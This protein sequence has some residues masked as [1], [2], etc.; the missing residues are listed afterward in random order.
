VVRALIAALAAVVPCALARAEAPSPG[1]DQRVA[2]I[3]GLLDAIESI[4][5]TELTNTSN[6]IYAVERNKCQAPVESLHVGCLL[7]ATARNC[8]SRQGAARERCNRASDVLVTNR[9]SETAFLPEDVRYEIMDKHRDYG[10]ALARELERRYAIVVAELVMSRHFPGSAADRTR[11]AAGI[12]SYCRELSS[13]RALPWQ[14]CV[15][16]VVWFIGTEGPRP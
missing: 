16:A 8:L 15:A 10:A 3:A 2:Y 4:E 12:E 1:R 9:L 7:E 6:Y 14:Y 13:T 11:L 5:R